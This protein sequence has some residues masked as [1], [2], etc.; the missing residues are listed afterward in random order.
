MNVT[1]LIQ[2][3]CIESNEI[4]YPR[5]T[6]VL[7]KEATMTQLRQ[8]IPTAAHATD[9]C[10][11]F[12]SHGSTFVAAGICC[13]LLLAGSSFAQTIPAADAKAAA[14]STLSAKPH[15]STEDKSIRPFHVSVPEAQLVDLRKRIA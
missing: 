9:G 1:L 7:R 15:T 6:V 8:V 13:L 5:Q 4:R 2:A 14:V 11:G 3:P 10:N 12:R